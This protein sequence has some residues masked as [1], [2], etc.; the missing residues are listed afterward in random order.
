MPSKKKNGKTINQTYKDLFSQENPDAVVVLDHML[1][2]LGVTKY[3]GGATMDELARADERRRYGFSL[4]RL[5]GLSEDFI[6][7][8]ANVQLTS[9]EERLYDDE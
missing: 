7:E 3:I 5:L 4:L 8:R 6:K 9:L 1:K 2:T